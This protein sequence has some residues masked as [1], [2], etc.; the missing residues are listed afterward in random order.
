MPLQVEGAK[1]LANDFRHADAQ[2]CGEILHSHLR[3]VFWILQQGNQTF[4]EAL[5]ISSLEEINRQAFL[6]SQFAKVG[7]IGGH[8]RHPVRAGQMR[9]A[10]GSRGRRVWHYRYGRALK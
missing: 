1:I 4:G 3:L 7:N 9:H 8:H 5:N 10:A 2:R 6:L